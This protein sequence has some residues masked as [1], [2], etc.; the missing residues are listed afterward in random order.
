MLLSF[1]SDRADDRVCPAPQTSSRCM[2]HHSF[3]SQC[4]SD[5]DCVGG[6]KCCSVECCLGNCIKKCIKPVLKGTFNIFF[7]NGYSVVLRGEMV[8][9]SLIEDNNATHILK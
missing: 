2:M 8:R 5:N 7:V 9:S 6:T 4:S 1:F 3:S